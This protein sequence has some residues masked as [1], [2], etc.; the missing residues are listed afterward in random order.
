MATIRK[1]PVTLTPE[2]ADTVSNLLGDLARIDF[3]HAKKS[4]SAAIRQFCLTRAEKA[5]KLETDIV[6]RMHQ[7]TE[8]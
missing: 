1:V 7:T 8:T 4:K 3:D 5:S 2:E 6:R